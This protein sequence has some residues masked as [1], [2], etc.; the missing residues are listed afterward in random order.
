MQAALMFQ[1]VVPSMKKK[2]KKNIFFLL[3]FQNKWEMTM[4]LNSSTYYQPRNLSFISKNTK[5]NDV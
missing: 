2:T 3:L 1:S 5:I 4:N